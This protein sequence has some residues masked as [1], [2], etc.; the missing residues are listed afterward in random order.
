MATTLE[1]S[2]RGEIANYVTGRATLSD[3]QDRLSVFVWDIDESR[4]PE[5][6]DILYSAELSFSEYDAGHISKWE[7]DHE[8]EAL[9]LYESSTGGVTD[10][11]FKSDSF[12]ADR[13][14]STG[15]ALRATY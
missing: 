3:L 9:V 13:R 2:V 5:A 8:L 6:S 15:R 10:L 11:T 14:S 1:K 4:D 7:L 12:A